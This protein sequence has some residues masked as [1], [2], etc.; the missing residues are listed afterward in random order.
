MKPFSMR[1]SLTIVVALAAVSPIPAMAS[2]RAICPGA[3]EGIG[4]IT[5]KSTDMRGTVF[6]RGAT[7]CTIKFEDIHKTAPDCSVSVIVEYH[8]SAKYLILVLRKSHS[9]SRLHYQP[10]LLIIIASLETDPIRLTGGK[11]CA[12]VTRTTSATVGATAAG[13]SSSR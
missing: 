3:P 10:K 6:A 2:G 1:K 5:T 7:R 13:S 11:S 8:I 12:K 9:Y 4:I